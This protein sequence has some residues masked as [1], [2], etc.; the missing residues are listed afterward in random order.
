M[1]NKPGETFEEV[2]AG[3][4]MA[5]SGDGSPRSRLRH[6]GREIGGFRK[7]TG[8]VTGLSTYE[9]GGFSDWQITR[10][11]IAVRASGV[12]QS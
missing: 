2:Y 7:T 8:G 12:R 3:L 11:E 4:A 10:T 5:V 1:P 9:Q 6:A